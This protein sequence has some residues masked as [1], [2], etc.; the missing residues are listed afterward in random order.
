MAV[1]VR[2]EQQA[3]ESDLI[4][5]GIYPATLTGIKQFENTYGARVGFE[6]TLRGGEVAT[7]TEQPPC[8][9]PVPI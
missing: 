1:V 2:Q 5:N 8:D 4:P 7:W 3:Q 9:P 6:F